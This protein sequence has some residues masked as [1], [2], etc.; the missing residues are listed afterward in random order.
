MSGLGNITRKEIRELLTPATFVPIILV[1]LIFATMG[2][3]IQGIQEQS[4]AP[5][6]IGVINEDNSTLGAIAST[7]LH[8]R[9]KVVY[10]S[11][12]RSDKQVGLE[13]LKEKNGVALIIIPQNFTERIRHEQ[14]GNIEVYWIMKGAGLM[15]TLSSSI[16]ESLIAYINTNISKELIQENTSIHNASFVLSPTKRL[17]TTY[18]KNREFQGLSPNTI[19]GM[20]SSQSLL[21][22]IVMMMIIIMAGSIVITSMALEKENKTLE[23]LL[24]LPVKRT[25]IVTGKIVAAAVIGLLLAIIYMIGMQFYFSGFQF[26]AGLNLASYGLVITSMDFIWIG[27]SLFITLIAGLSL[28]MLMG[29]FAKNYK[30]AQT[31]TFPI[32]MLAM[33]PMFITM[34]AD[35]DTLPLALKIF[36]FA[37]PFSHPMMAP[38]A[39]LFHD[40]TL[41]IGGIV[42]VAIFA[43]V[44]ISI[45]VWVFKTDRLLVGTTKFKWLKG[46]TRRR[47]F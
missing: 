33:I 19:S 14:P 38:R 46:L 16:F 28:C 27:V 31:L 47:R 41:V 15:D 10:N 36:T 7:I 23:T 9:A 25:S 43:I 42:Y 6:T 22:P 1:A 37:I 8:E 35:F 24:T 21:I 39:L 30:S 3:S 44:T 32:T 17:E 45:V 12:S 34:F 20:L 40:Y 26:S 11:T 5:P 13:T 2:N 18:F 29:T 4:Q